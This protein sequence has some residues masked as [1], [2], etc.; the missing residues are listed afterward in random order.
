MLVDSQVC[1]CQDETA[2]G[3]PISPVPWLQKGFASTME[4]RKCVEMS[5]RLDPTYSLSKILEANPFR[6]VLCAGWGGSSEN[7]DFSRMPQ[8]TLQKVFCSTPR[9]RTRTLSCQAL[10]RT[11]QL[12]HPLEGGVGA[13]TASF[14]PFP[15]RKPWEVINLYVLAKNTHVSPQ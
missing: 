11:R 7:G 4:T 3:W 13:K 6:Y 15:S 8:K 2:C 1:G 9:K 12:Q 10:W 14:G 5:T